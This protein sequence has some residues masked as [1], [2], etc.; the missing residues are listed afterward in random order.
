MDK[1]GDIIASAA[2]ALWLSMVAFLDNL[3]E[4]GAIAAVALIFFLFFKGE[5][6][7]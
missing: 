1:A 5:L 3:G 7:A 4:I 2:T 6:A